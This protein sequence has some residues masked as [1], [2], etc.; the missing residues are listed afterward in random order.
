HRWV[1]KATGTTHADVADQL[2]KLRDTNRQLAEQYH[3]VEAKQR[4]AS[5]VLLEGSVQDARPALSGSSPLMQ[6]S[7]AFFRSGMPTSSSAKDSTEAPRLRLVSTRA[8]E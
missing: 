2:A 8:L 7:D 4:G 6:L 1:K 3:F 5:A